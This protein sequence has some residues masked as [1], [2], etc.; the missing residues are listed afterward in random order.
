MKKIA[1]RLLVLLITAGVV[2]GAVYLVQQIPKDEIEIAVAPV[3][4]GDLEV[5]SFL[6]G[7]LQAVRSLTLTAPNLGSTSQITRLAPQGALARHGDLILELDDSDRIAALEDSQLDVDKINEDLKKAQTDLEIRKSQDEVELVRANYAVERAQLEMKRNELISTIDARKNELTLEEANRRLDKLKQ[8]IKSRL[9]QREA[10][11]AVLRENLRKAQL[12]VDRER[13]RIA[14]AR[15]LAPITGLVSILENNAGGRGG[16]GQTMPTIQEGDQIPPGMSV[17][18]ILDLSEMELITKVEETERANLSEGQEAIVRL[19]AL[20]KRIVTAKIK[21]LGNTASSNVFRGEATKKFE[22]VLSIDMRQL[23]ENVG[24][25]PEQIER[26]LAT[27][28]QNAASGVGGGRRPVGQLLAFGAPPGGEGGES[29]G[30]GGGGPRAGRRRGGPGGGQQPDGGPGAP[31]QAGGENAQRKGGPGG[32]GGFDRAQFQK[33]V[34]EISGKELSELSEDERR[35]VMQQ[36]RQRMGGG[37]GGP[38]GARRGAG[39]PGGAGPGGPGGLIPP[40]LEGAG[41]GAGGGGGDPQFSAE[42]RANAQLPAP[43]EQGSDVDILLRPGLLA[44]A[45]IIVEKIP[46]ALH[47]PFQGVFEV[48]GK[49]TVFVQKGEN[50]FELRHVEL[51]KRSESQITVRSGLEEGEMIAL[52]APPEFGDRVAQTTKAAKKA[53][54]RVG[55]AGGGPG[56]PGGGGGGAQGGGGGGQGRR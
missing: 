39:G 3:K 31:P 29:Q 8:D 35:S 52:T 44:D 26:I 47:I 4:R 43:P 38:G 33:L 19:D 42:Q 16:F 37:A 1:T 51:G 49:P 18:Q 17:A 28:K 46:D 54:A 36:V 23:L 5:K 13:R 40:P 53:G 14:Q 24:A 22:C 11:L 15:V 20:P 32:R 6:R 34:K 48:D 21:R 30:Q 55:P 2:A 10:E 12:E 50:R 9:Q 45:E 41:G 7:E 25:K 56:L 27:A